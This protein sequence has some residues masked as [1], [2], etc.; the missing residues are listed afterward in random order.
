MVLCQDLVQNKMRF[1]LLNHFLL[2]SGSD[3]LIKLFVLIRRHIVTV[4]MDTDGIV[5]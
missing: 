3:L 5:K 2:L 4:T 1:S